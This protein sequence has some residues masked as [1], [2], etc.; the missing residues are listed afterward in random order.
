MGEPG[1][2]QRTGKLGEDT[3]VQ[4]LQGN[5]YRIL[6]RNFRTRY[7]EVDIIAQ[8]DG[9]LVFVEV[10]AKASREFGLPEESLTR[11]KKEHLVSAAEAYLQELGLQDIPWRI[12]LVSV[13]VGPL[14]KVND[15]RHFENAV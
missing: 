3:A 11:A 12:D 9:C 6:E 2:R 4:Y 14:G 5:G 10:R 13:D 1:R 15:V 8:K 7:G